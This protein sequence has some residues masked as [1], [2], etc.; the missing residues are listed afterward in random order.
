MNPTYD[1]RLGQT[2]LHQHS[3]ED[4]TPARI[5]TDPLDDTLQI[6][7]TK[8]ELIEG[9]SYENNT[10]QP[11]FTISVTKD[12][13]GKSVLLQTGRLAEGA[14]VPLPEGA[15]IV[16][17]AWSRIYRNTVEIYCYQTGRYMLTIT[18]KTKA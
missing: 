12:Q 17:G 10:E 2:L 15:E 4:L 18:Q 14:S 13:P 16:S 1:A 9:S 3:P 6:D 5:A 7:M 8:K 11:S